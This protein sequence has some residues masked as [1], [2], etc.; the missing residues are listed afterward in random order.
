MLERWPPCCWSRQSALAKDI[1][2]AAVGADLA[3]PI[4]IIG[5]PPLAWGAAK[6]FNIRLKVFQAPGQQTYTGSLMGTP[7][8]FTELSELLEEEGQGAVANAIAVC[9]PFGE[10]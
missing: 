9:I 8:L 10:A 4:E 3:G 6:Y 5:W 7:E 2:C 1:C